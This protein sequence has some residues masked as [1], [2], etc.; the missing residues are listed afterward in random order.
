[1]Q[2]LIL[3][4]GLGTRL[5]KVVNDRPKP[6]ALIENKPF[7][8]YVLLHLKKNCIH[9]VVMAVG[10]KG[11]LIEE[12]F[13]NG[14]LLGMEIKYSYETM[15]LG[16]AGAIKN[17]ERFLADTF[18]VLNGDTYFNMDYTRHLSLHTE[19]AAKI[20]MVLRE[21]DDVSRYG[22]VA[23]DKDGAVTAF[24]EK[25]CVHGRG[26]INGGVY[27]MQKDILKEIPPGV[28]CALET[29][30]LPRILF[31]YRVFAWT[32]SG[33][34]IDIGIPED[35]YKFQTELKNGKIGKP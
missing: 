7:L 30:L 10:F 34:F 27:L 23:V 6:M 3:A 1:M 17:A 18:W 16:T 14:H 29:D 33:Y 11:N 19:A 32:S 5:S 15:R 25:K 2:A 35:Y 28:N 20:S 26:V 31:N 12:H 13:G 22:S 21:V 9:E 4:G 8:E 24:H